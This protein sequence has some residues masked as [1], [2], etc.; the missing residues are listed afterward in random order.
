MQKQKNNNFSNR[1]N[2]ESVWKNEYKDRL[3]RMREK[4]YFLNIEMLIYLIYI[5]INISIY[6][7]YKKVG[8]SWEYQE[9]PV[10]PPMI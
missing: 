9:Y 2:I 3:K 1:A 6:L 7:V 4:F 8:Y 5:Y 10:Y